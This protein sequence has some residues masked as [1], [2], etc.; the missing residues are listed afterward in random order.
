MTT[1]KPTWAE[2]V[3]SILA[4]RARKSDRTWLAGEI[5]MDR[6]QL[7]RLMNGKE[8]S[9]GGRYLLNDDIRAAI[10]G[11]LELP[12]DLIFGTDEGDQPGP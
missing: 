10:A 8:T 2:R 3:D 7:S 12:E 11:A 4:T 6:T 5:A 1:A 9:T